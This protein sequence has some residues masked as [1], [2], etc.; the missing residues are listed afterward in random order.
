MQQHHSLSTGVPS[1]AYKH[2]LCLPKERPQ[3]SNIHHTAPDAMLDPTQEDFK[4]AI[5]FVSFPTRHGRAAGIRNFHTGTYHPLIHNLSPLG[6]LQGFLVRSVS[7]KALQG[8][9]TDRTKTHINT[10]THT[11]KDSFGCVHQLHGAS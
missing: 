3:T 7:S 9:P 4:V 11:Y 1:A 2:S 5:R 10:H 8:K 6:A